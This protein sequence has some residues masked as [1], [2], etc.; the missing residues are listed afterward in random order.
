MC[1][2]FSHETRQPSEDGVAIGAC[3]P[4]PCARMKVSE[5]PAL[6][7]SIPGSVRERIAGQIA[8]VLYAPLDDATGDFSPES[9]RTQLEARQKEFVTGEL[10]SAPLDWTL[11]RKAT[12]LFSNDDVLTVD[13]SNVGYLGGAHGFNERTLLCFALVDGRRLTLTEIINPDSKGVLQQVAE[14]EFRRVR[15]I[16]VGRSLQDEG[17]FV[18]PGEPFGVADNFGVV[19][20]GI[21]LHYNPYD[22]GPYVMGETDVLLPREAVAPLLKEGALRVAHLF[23]S[24]E[25]KR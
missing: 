7:E 23:D 19:A 2:C 18:V 12:V 10:S 21:L 13:V 5:A 11:E 25:S 22:I 17:F 15:R 4:F 20:G 6:P 14:A 16:P 1:G 24:A 8:E 9:L 3:N